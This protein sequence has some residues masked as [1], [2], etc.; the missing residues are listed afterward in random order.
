MTPLAPGSW[1][2]IQYQP[3]FPTIE[4]DLTDMP[5]WEGKGHETSTS[6]KDL[7]TT[8]SAEAGEIEKSCSPGKNTPTGHSILNGQP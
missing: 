6:D 8:R 5:V 4:P 2:G 7:Q 3:S 1:L